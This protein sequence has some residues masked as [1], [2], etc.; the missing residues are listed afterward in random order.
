M[1]KLTRLV[2]AAGCTG[3]VASAAIVGTGVIGGTA[4]GSTTTGPTEAGVSSSSGEVE[5]ATVEEVPASLPSGGVN[6]NGQVVLRPMTTPTS[7]PSSYLTE[8]EAAM[9]AKRE[10][11]DSALSEGKPLL[12]SVTMPGSVAPAGSTI[13]YHTIADVPGWVVTFTAPKPINVNLGPSGSPPLMMQHY[14]VAINASTGEF[15]LG[16]FTR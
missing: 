9:I 11:T 3:V 1:K 8:S 14:S 5:P 10:A 2:V 7:N 13:P 16:F 15:I 4:S 12:A 6:V